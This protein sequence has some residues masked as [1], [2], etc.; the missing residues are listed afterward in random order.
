[1]L[2][3]DVSDTVNPSSPE[4]TL[5]YLPREAVGFRVLISQVSELAV[6]DV[7]SALSHVILR[8]TI[9]SLVQVDHLHRKRSVRP[10]SQEAGAP[11]YQFWRS[12]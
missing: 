10:E 11:G 5:G 4:S 3:G 8:I 6:H 9:A 12:R 1:M 7:H 2:R